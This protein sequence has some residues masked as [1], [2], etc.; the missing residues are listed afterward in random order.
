MA[1]VVH[2]AI[3]HLDWKQPLEAVGK[4]EEEPL[5]TF[6]RLADRSDRRPAIKKHMILHMYNSIVLLL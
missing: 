1:L 5:D 6:H 4:L 3:R 2:Y